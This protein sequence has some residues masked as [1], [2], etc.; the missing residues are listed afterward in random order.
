MERKITLA[1]YMAMPVMH[2][3][4][5]MPISNMTMR[6]FMV[7]SLMNDDYEDYLHIPLTA[8]PYF[9]SLQSDKRVSWQR[10]FIQFWKMEMIAALS[11]TME[12]WSE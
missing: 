6:E 12:G 4:P 8:I 3:N 9:R 5:L 2:P 7:L 1:E 10:N 11:A